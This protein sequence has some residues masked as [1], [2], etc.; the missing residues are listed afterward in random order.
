MKRIVI[1]STRGG[2]G[3]TSVAA[4]LTSA[5]NAIGQKAH[6][7]D[8]NPNNLLRLH[9]AMPIDDP[10]G[11][12]HQVLNANSW[13][14]A[15]YVSNQKIAFVPFGQLDFAQSNQLA[16]KVD[17]LGYQ[18]LITPLS[19]PNDWQLVLL[20]ALEHLTSAHFE[21]CQSAD[22]VLCVGKA[23]FQHYSLLPQSLHFAKL[24]RYCQPHL[25]LNMINPSSENS[26]DMLLVFQNELQD[27]V[28]V[29][30]HQDTALDDAILNMMPV[31][32]YAPYSQIARDF[33]ALAF[34]CLSRLNQRE[35]KP[36]LQNQSN[37]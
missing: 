22:L 9:F 26:R 37:L 21:F 10:A 1:L 17:A 5:L 24:R 18:E 27:L 19:D 31:L 6:V 36:N 12:S 30:L 11:W 29:V 16:A 35:V 32:D 28:P 13:K 33:H 3:A 23:D 15:G 34:W 7:V 4:N 20:P 8:L 25:L 14:N 2:T